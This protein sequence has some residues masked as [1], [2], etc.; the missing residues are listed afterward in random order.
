MYTGRQSTDQVIGVYTEKTFQP[1]P[2]KGLCAKEIKRVPATRLVLKCF[3]GSTL[4]SMNAVE[5]K[6]RY[7]HKKNV[8]AAKCNCQP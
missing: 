6:A 1:I 8:P 2:Y 5:R 3:K 4:P 7:T